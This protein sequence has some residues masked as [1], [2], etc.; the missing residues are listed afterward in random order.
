MSR[1]FKDTPMTPADTITYWVEYIARHGKD[2]LRSPV[3]DMP[4]WQAD[5]LDIYGFILLLILVVFWVIKVIVKLII[6]GIVSSKNNSSSHLKKK[7][8]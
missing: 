6:S 5:L 1:K 2:A 7:S 4:W 3:L 8:S